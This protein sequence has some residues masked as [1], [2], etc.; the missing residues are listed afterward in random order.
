MRKWVQCPLA[1]SAL[2][3]ND[4]SVNSS[5]QAQDVL[6]L[7]CLK[8]QAHF[9]VCVIHG[10]NI[11]F[12]VLNFV[13][14]IVKTCHYCSIEHASFVKFIVKTCHYCS[15]AHASFVPFIVKTCHYCS[16]E[17]ASFVPFIVKT[18]HYCSIEHASFVPFI[19]KT[20]HYCSTEH[21]LAK[22]INLSLF[23]L[24]SFMP[25]VF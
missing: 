14:F 24:F 17:H 10:T 15:I 12:T 11:Y 18:C 21:P 4:I 7:S 19:V 8:P 22:P 6:W 20:C 5:C 2:M 3:L 13:I 25:T 16:I 1:E 9:G 23:F